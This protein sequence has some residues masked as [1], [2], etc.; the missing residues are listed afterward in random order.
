MPIR[1][2]ALY[3]HAAVYFMSGDKDP[4]GECGKGVKLAYENFK[5]AGMKDVSIKLYKDGR[6]EMLN[7]I[8]KAEV[9]ADILAWINSRI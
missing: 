6:H 2:A 1:F 4:V 7:E 9:Y 3:R 5:K 8:N